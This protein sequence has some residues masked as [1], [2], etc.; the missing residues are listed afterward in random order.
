[1]PYDEDEYWKSQK[2]N[3]GRRDKYSEGSVADRG[4]DYERE[5]FTTTPLFNKPN[6]NKITGYGFGSKK[7]NKNSSNS[8][9]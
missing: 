7:K 5:G 8:S 1:M 4:G 2:T 3:K 6:R 9:Y